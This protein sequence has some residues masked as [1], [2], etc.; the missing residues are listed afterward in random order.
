MKMEEVSYEE[1]K[2]LREFEDIHW[3][4]PVLNN[5]RGYKRG[6]DRQ[7]RAAGNV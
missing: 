1:A 6:D 2:L 5:Q 4:L 7:Y 3:D